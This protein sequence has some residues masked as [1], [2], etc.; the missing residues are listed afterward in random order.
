M[1]NVQREFETVDLLLKS[2][3]QT[4]RTDAFI[5]SWVK[6]EKQIRKLFVYMVFQFL[7]FSPSNKNEIIKAFVPFR[8]LYFDNYISGFDA[9]YR[10][11]FQ[12]I[13]GGDYDELR[14]KLDEI[15]KK[16]RNKI[17]HGQLTG[18][19][20]NAKQLSEQV[21]VMR[22]WITLIA[23]KL[24]SEIGYDGLE[25]SA[26][27]KFKEPTF[28]SSFQFQIGNVKELDTFIKESMGGRI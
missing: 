20:L 5:L 15:R 9:I 1:K 21:E 14:P 8:N 23:E 3:S 22:K 12:Q 24:S 6:V 2:E 18:H 16:Y 4:G 25:S 11:S 13:V 10:T 19:G 7:A 17:L 27:R 28:S 26:F